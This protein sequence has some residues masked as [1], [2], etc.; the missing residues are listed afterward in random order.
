VSAAKAPFTFDTIS[1]MMFNLASDLE[2]ADIL[3]MNDIT[4]S[5]IPTVYRTRL[6]ILKAFNQS[7]G[8]SVTTTKLSTLEYCVNV[9]IL[10]NE[11]L[12]NCKVFFNHENI[13]MHETNLQTSLQYFE[14]WKNYCDSIGDNDGF[15]PMI[16]YNNLRST[17]CGFFAYA[18]L[19]VSNRVGGMGPMIYVPSLHSNQ[20]TLESWFSLVRSMHK[21]NTRDYGTVVSTR[22]ASSGSDIIKAQRNKCY[23]ALDIAEEQGCKETTI[24]QALYH[25][26][27]RREKKM[28]SIIAG[29]LTV[30]QDE[31]V[32]WSP[33]LFDESEE[34]T[35]VLD[36]ANYCI[37]ANRL[38]RSRELCFQ[39]IQSNF[40]GVQNFSD[41][42]C[43]DSQ[44][45]YHPIKDMFMVYCQMGLESPSESFLTTIFDFTSCEKQEFD[46]SCRTVF[47]TI[48]NI[49]YCELL[50][51]KNPKTLESFYALIYVNFISKQEL[52]HRNWI[53][54]LPQ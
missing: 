31:Y 50:Q 28:Q 8:D 53:L 43:S 19:I 37:D 10:F 18:K 16:T 12:L 48:L 7:H 45:E 24:E 22:N 17:V 46:K 41:M 33:F 38:A 49:V 4:E 11:T 26:D 6:D 14:N 30:A 35:G 25:H 21:D 44:S 5:Y 27:S 3:F 51:K 42:L 32:S 9:A 52:Y 34:A 36:M 47:R 13:K 1:E 39:I 23:S 54:H 20:S 2:C 40:V 29:H 15:L